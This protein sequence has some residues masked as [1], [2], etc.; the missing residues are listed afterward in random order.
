VCEAFSRRLGRPVTM[1][2]AGLGP[3]GTAQHTSPDIVTGLIDLGSADMDPTRRAVL[4]A[5]GLYSAALAIPG[6]ADVSRRFA[7]LQ[8]NPHLRIGQA[9]VDAVRAMTDHLS[10]F[11]DQFGGRIVR[12]MAAAFLVNTIAPYL[13]AE[14]A[15]DI[16]TEMLSAAADHCYLLT[17]PRML[18]FLTGQQ[19]HATAQSDD[20]P[21]ALRLLR[22]AETAMD[23][24]E[25]QAKTFGSYD[26]ASLNYHIAQVRYE[27]GDR[28]ASIAA[29]ETADRVRP[30]VYRRAHVRHLGTL[31]ERKLE[32]GRLEEACRDWDRMLD[33]YTAVQSGRCD[34][35]FN[36]MMRALRPHLR[37]PYAKDLHERGRTLS[38]RQRK[39]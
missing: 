13:Q 27:L 19:A 7:M 18:A 38:P 12:P 35:R 20:R 39:T 2:S 26:P 21:R 4:G 30:Q 22:A 16:R 9:E 24:A 33:D 5:A 29:L 23:R 36:A 11:D 25:S 1:A 8:T 28:K 34:D 14:A 3:A 17:G 6:W 31:A 10:T 37:N 15:P 32:I